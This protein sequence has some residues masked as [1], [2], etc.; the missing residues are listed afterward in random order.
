MVVTIFVPNIYAIKLGK[1]KNIRPKKRIP[2]TRILR[3]PSKRS[4]KASQGQATLSTTRKAVSASTVEREVVKSTTPSVPN[5]S[6]PM[7]HLSLAVVERG[8]SYA[9]KH[10]ESMTEEAVSEAVAQAQHEIFMRAQE[11]VAEHGRWM[12]TADLRPGTPS[13]FLKSETYR[14]LKK[15]LPSKEEVELANLAARTMIYGDAKNPAVMQLIEL[16]ESFLPENIQQRHPMSIIRETVQFFQRE[17][18]LMKEDAHSPTL[19]KETKLS[20]EMTH[21]R[22]NYE[23]YPILTAEDP[24]IAK[25]DEIIKDAQEEQAA[26]GTLEQL[27]HFIATEGHLPETHGWDGDFHTLN[28]YRDHPEYEEMRLYD[29]VQFWMTRYR[30]GESKATDLMRQLWKEYGEKK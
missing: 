27:N 19:A 21:L 10:P 29:L 2:I 13:P 12:K 23:R 28:Q 26:S 14:K 25:F 9:N 18:R 24:V 16:Y 5:T 22:S 1:M 4:N 6:R 3:I 8:L 17:G 7:Q 11:F 30:P 15:E 20:K